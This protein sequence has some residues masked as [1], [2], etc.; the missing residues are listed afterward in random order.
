MLTFDTVQVLASLT[1]FAGILASIML[2]GPKLSVQLIKSYDFSLNH[3][4]AGLT[5]TLSL[6]LVLINWELR[7]KQTYVV[8]DGPIYEETVIIPPTIHPKKKVPP[9]PA[10]PKVTKQKRTPVITYKATDDPVE[11]SPIKDP[12]DLVT[13]PAMDTIS[14]GEPAPPTPLPV[15]PEDNNEIVR[16]PDQMPRFPGCEGLSAGHKE[17]YTCAT[18]QLLHYLYKEIKYPTMA[19]N[20]GIEGTAVIQFVV[21]PDGL[22]SNVKVL[23]DPGGGCAKEA[24]RVVDKM[25]KMSETWTP[26][27]QNGRP[28]R[29]LYTLPVKFKLR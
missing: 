3:F 29:V 19:R 24:T 15:V 5:M 4:L 22:I 20:L 9:P 8:N 13:A 12:Q 7:N 26:G 6:I 18:E 2:L 21:E 10:P 23:R 14:Y 16:I 1:L 27:K 17:K 25:N 28:V 11:S